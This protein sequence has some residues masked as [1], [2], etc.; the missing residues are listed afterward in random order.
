MTY[1]SKNHFAEL[2]FYFLSP[3]HLGFGRHRF[4]QVHSGRSENSSKNKK[5]RTYKLSSYGFII[6]IID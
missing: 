6:A 1:L 4:Y 2:S 5:T 3:D